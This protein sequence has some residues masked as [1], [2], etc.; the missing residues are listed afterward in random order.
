MI[1]S[2]MM[3]TGR[4][5]WPELAIPQR[6]PLMTSQCT[7]FPPSL[8]RTQP[9]TLPR[10]PPPSLSSRIATV[11]HRPVPLNR[12]VASSRTPR[13]PR[14]R[15]AAATSCA[16][17]RAT[18]RATS[19]RARTI[20]RGF[21]SCP[22]AQQRAASTRREKQRRARVARERRRRRRRVKRPRQRRK[23]RRR[24]RKRRPWRER[25]NQRRTK[26][27]VLGWSSEQIKLSLLPLTDSYRDGC[28]RFS[29]RSHDACE[30]AQRAL[31]LR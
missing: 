14:C 23:R 15:S 24:R 28:M 13:R 18:L 7:G 8:P 21:R 6:K 10:P 9:R 19:Q 16:T 31:Q 12:R 11:L 5:A 22:R 26:M 1:K 3:R 17:S 2:R 4:A 30:G 27:K 20:P 29:R 25:R